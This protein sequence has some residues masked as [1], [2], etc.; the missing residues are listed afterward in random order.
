MYETL[1]GLVWFY[2]KHMK[3]KKSTVQVNNNFKWAVFFAE[4]SSKEYH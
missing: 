4:R 3:S 2:E 1:S